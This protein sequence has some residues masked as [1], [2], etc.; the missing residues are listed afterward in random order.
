MKLVQEMRERQTFQQP[1]KTNLL[2]MILGVVMAFGIGAAGVGAL[3]DASR[4][5][6]LWNDETVAL[7]SALKSEASIDDSRARDG[8]AE[9]A[10]LLRTCFPFSKLG[11]AAEQIMPTTEIYKKMQ[12]ASQ[13]M[14]VAAMAGLEKESAG[15]V[16]FAWLWGNVADCVY[17][18]N[19]WALCNPDNRALAIEA[20]STFLRQL[21]AA[22]KE[23]AV[24]KFDNTNAGARRRQDRAYALQNANAIKDRVLSSLRYRV[25]EGRLNASDFGM[26]APSE[27][28]QIVRDTKVTGSGCTG[29]R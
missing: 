14:R 25:A 2:P 29:G 5:T 6:S 1:K 16:E 24:E 28:A 11:I 21:Q 3:V 10:L 7:P 19:G 13:M 17:R 26:F 8:A 9:A 23:K 15:G 18:Q 12:M 20:A 22:E 4:F 27:I